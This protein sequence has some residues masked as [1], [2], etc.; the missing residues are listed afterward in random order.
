MQRYYNSTECLDEERKDPQILLP[1]GKLLLVSL[2]I[3]E[4]VDHHFS[5]VF[6]M[7]WIRD[8]TEIISVGADQTCKIMNVETLQTV[9]SVHDHIASIKCVTLSNDERIIATGGRDGKINFYDER[10]GLMN[11]IHSFTF[12]Q[13]KFG[14]ANLNTCRK[15]QQ[16][17]GGGPKHPVAQ[18]PTVTGLAF[19]KNYML[20]VVESLSD[21]IT[22]LDIRKLSSAAD[23]V[24]TPKT[25]KALNDKLCIGYLDNNY[26]RKTFGDNCQASK[27]CSWIAL[28]NFKMVVNSLDNMI[29]LYDMTSLISQ[30]PVRL[31]GHTS[32]SDFYGELKHFVLIRFI[33]RANFGF[34]DDF[35]VS[36]SEE[37]FVHIWDLKKS[38]MIGSLGSKTNEYG[39]IS[40]VNEVIT[41]GQDM[42]VSASDDCSVLVWSL[43]RS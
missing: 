34:D 13:L 2:I 43:I 3:A 7:Q 18:V 38:K 33:V 23:T 5:S 22:M 16:T 39:H 19:S 4:I 30:P 25:E 42:I 31:T 14:Q 9:D 17:V 27:G 12:T 29:N 10:Q 11:Q 40:E 26:F 37:N 36:G 8:D 1:I 28:K 35:I 32:K 21:K 24:R 20:S 6:D 15:G 41:I